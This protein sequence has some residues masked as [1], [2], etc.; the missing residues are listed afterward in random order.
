MA[1]KSRLEDFRRVFTWHPLF[2]DLALSWQ[3]CLCHAAKS[4]QFKGLRWAQE[5]E[6]GF[7]PA[8]SPGLGN[9][10]SLGGSRFTDPP[11]EPG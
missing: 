11:S 8:D 9:A 6:S 5:L 1:N 2:L 7:S 4:H 10:A 3:Q